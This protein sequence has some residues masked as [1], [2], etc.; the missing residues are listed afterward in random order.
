MSR[1]RRPTTHRR[2]TSISRRRSGRGA[3]RPRRSG[4][5]AGGGDSHAPGGGIECPRSPSKN[6]GGRLA[7]AKLPQA[8]SSATP[9]RRV[10]AWPSPPPESLF[11]RHAPTGRR[12]ASRSR[13]SGHFFDGLLGAKQLADDGSVRLPL[14]GDREV[15]TRRPPGR[16]QPADVPAAGARRSCSAVT[17]DP[18][19]PQR[20][21]P[22]GPS[23]PGQRDRVGDVGVG[24]R[25]LLEVQGHDGGPLDLAGVGGA[26]PDVEEAVRVEEPEVA[27]HVPAVVERRGPRPADVAGRHPRQPHLD[28]ALLAI[29]CRAAPVGRDHPDL[30]PGRGLSRGARAVRG[31]RGRT[32]GG[33]DADSAGLAGAIGVDEDRSQPA[34][35]G[36]RR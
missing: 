35:A 11:A 30:D 1:S 3:G 27:G 29:R 9:I 19:D 18:C 12:V 8:A 14:L 20:Q 21:H 15:V 5:R 10:S 28:D 26:A 36:A 31:G 17:A 33:E 25:R 23:W 16:R 22:E 13:S 32:R 24:A 4:A 2:M 6:P 7:A 34:R